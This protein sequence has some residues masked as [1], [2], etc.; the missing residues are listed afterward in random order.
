MYP[1]THEAQRAIAQAGD[2]AK[3]SRRGRTTLEDLLITLAG[4]DIASTSGPLA[5]CG[6]DAAELE[7]SFGALSALSRHPAQT[8]GS[9]RVRVGPPALDHETKRAVQLAVEE[10]LLHNLDEIDARG[11]LMGV[12]SQPST[13]AG[14]V[15]AGAGLT[16]ESLRAALYGD[17]P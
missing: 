10:T 12:A 4:S 9:A 7:T 8:G 2:R 13:T 16:A 3:R 17:V 6:S 14:R 1:F 11:L 5:A 15:L